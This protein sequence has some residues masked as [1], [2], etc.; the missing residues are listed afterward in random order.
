[1]PKTG[2]TSKGAKGK[3]I[4]AKSE[5]PRLRNVEFPLPSNWAALQATCEPLQ[6]QNKTE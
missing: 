6:E 4:L 5:M 2:L 3:S 1:M